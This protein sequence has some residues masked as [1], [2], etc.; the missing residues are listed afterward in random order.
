MS[1]KKYENRKLVELFYI[2]DLFLICHKQRL[3]ESEFDCN[4]ILYLGTTYSD[5]SLT[6]FFRTDRTSGF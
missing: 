5:F 2:I 6:E 1:L 3:N 4:E